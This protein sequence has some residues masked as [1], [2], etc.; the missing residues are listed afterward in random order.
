MTEERR[1]DC[2][3]CGRKTTQTKEP[4]KVFANM[5]CVVWKC[6]RCGCNYLELAREAT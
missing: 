5:K 6:L 2:F 1:T 3:L 4:P